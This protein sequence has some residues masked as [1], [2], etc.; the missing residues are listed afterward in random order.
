[1]NRIYFF[2][3]LY[4]LF[5][6]FACLFSE[7]FLI[8]PH[9]HCIS[10]DKLYK[11]HVPGPLSER[12]PVRFGQW[13]ALVGDWGLGERNQSI[14]SLSL[15]GSEYTPYID[16]RVSS[17]CGSLVDGHTLCL[18]AAPLP[19]QAV[20]ASGP[21]DAVFCLGSSSSKADRILAIAN[22]WLPSF[23]VWLLSTANTFCN[24]FPKINVF[25]EINVA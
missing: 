2:L 10:K 20:L 13:E 1:M 6:S 18:W 12:L 8:F 11:L 4:H 17:L 25:T 14:S 21:D 15:Q 16:Q 23:V 24:Y 3:L 7:P 5:R 9:Q 22:L 19:T